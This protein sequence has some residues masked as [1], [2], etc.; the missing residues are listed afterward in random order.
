MA[1]IDRILQEPSYGWQ[2]EKGE[3]VIPTKRVMLKEALSRLNI[4]RSKKNWISFVGWFQVI[5]I[6]PCLYFFVTRYFSIPLFLL[7]MVYA[8]I[9]MGTHGTIWYHRY[10]THKAYK[11]KNAFWRFFTQNLVIRTL[12]EEIYAISH[13]VHH[14]KSDLPGDP[15]NST[16]GL[17]YCLL[18]ELNHQRVNMDLSE[19]D[20]NKTSRMMSHTGIWINSYKQYQKW[21]SIVHPVYTIGVL[22]FNWAFWGTALYLLGGFALVTALFS[23]AMLWFLLVR[24]FNYTGHGKGEVKHVDGLDFDRTNLAINQTRPGMF[25]G[26]WHNNHHLY[27]ASARA[28]FLPNQ[29]DPAWMYIYTMYKLGAVTSYHDYKEDFLRKYGTAAQQAKQPV[30]PPSQPLKSKQRREPA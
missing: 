11:F 9:I 19:A 3:L 22:L 5:C 14:A 28:G 25:T 17:T 8:M 23:A 7:V 27:P 20:Y 16:A 29:I 4:F 26:E 10:C 13:H 30:A 12:P 15:Y 2:N 21:G 24:I 1:L 6:L 18:A